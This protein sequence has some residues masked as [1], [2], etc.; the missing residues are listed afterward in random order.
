MATSESKPRK[1]SPEANR[2]AAVPLLQLLSQAVLRTFD[3]KNV[4]YQS[5]K[6]Y[7]EYVY[8]IND[9]IVAFYHELSQAMG[10]KDST[11]F[12]NGTKLAPDMYRKFGPTVMLPPFMDRG[13]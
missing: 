7:L 2:A 4:E 5:L 1:T 10:L 13:V 3:F 8:M 6:L 11:F 12:S 9:R